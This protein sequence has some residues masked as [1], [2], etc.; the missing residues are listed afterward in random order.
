VH[1]KI[2]NFLIMK[3]VEKRFRRAAAATAAHKLSWVFGMR[4]ASENSGQ[5]NSGQLYGDRGT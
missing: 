1:K 3:K 5:K 2:T 4:F